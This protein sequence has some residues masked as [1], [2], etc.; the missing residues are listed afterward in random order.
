MARTIIHSSSRSKSSNRSSPL[1]SP[2][3]R[4]ACVVTAD[5][6]RSVILNEVKNLAFAIGYTN[7]ILRLSPQNDISTQSRRGEGL[8]RGI[9]EL[10]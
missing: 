9:E 8:T 3:P 5:A 1:L 6:P 2:P 10:G 7:Q 4:S